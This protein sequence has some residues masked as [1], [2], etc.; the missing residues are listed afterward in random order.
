MERSLATWEFGHLV[1]SARSTVGGGARWTVVRGLHMSVVRL[2]DDQWSNIIAQSR[3]RHKNNECPPTGDLVPR[4]ETP[5]PNPS[6]KRT[7]GRS[8][9]YAVGLEADSPN[10]DWGI[11]ERG[12]DALVQSFQPSPVL[13]HIELAIPPALPQEGA[14]TSQYHDF[15]SDGRHVHFATYLGKRADWGSQF[16][17]S[18]D[19]YLEKN[20]ESWRATPVIAWDAA[21]RIREEC[22]YNHTCTPYAPIYRLYNYPFSIPPLRSIAWTLDDQP[23]TAAHCATLSARVLRRALPEIDL[24]NSSPWYGPSTLCLELASERRMRAYQRQISDYDASRSIAEVE[25]D[26]TFADRAEHVLLRGSDLEVCRLTQE[27]CHLGTEALARKAMSAVVNHDATM[28]RMWQKNLAKALMRWSHVRG[29]KEVH[30][31]V[32][33]ESSGNEGE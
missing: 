6:R 16:E 25:D 10:A 24:P 9:G 20:F 14:S 13:T 22:E 4:A 29:A 19:F 32:A 12:I 2:T 23:K 7:T 31:R 21:N 28:A 15:H 3:S 5:P 17:D 30:P 27:E 26:S 8:F 33:D 1:E 11:F 18:V